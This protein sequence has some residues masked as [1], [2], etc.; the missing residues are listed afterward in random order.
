MTSDRQSQSESTSSKI[1]RE[2]NLVGEG[3]SGF[4]DAAR[5][6]FTNHKTETLIEAGGSVAVG[7]GLA[8]ARSLPRI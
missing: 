5:D 7:I 3:L 1:E 4:T 6:A 2:L 8:A